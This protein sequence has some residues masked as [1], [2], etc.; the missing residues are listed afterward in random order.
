MNNERISA[1][2]YE[3][4]SA[5]L[6]NEL[7]QEE[8]RR[9]A[10]RL[11]NEP[12]LK[13]ALEAIRRTRHILRSQPLMRAP[14]NYTLSRQMVAEKKSLF[15]FKWG[16]KPAI[17][18]A[19]ALASVVFAILFLY[20]FV[21][22]Q[23]GLNR[24]PMA[25]A[26]APQQESVMQEAAPTQAV[27]DQQLRSAPSP[28]P[29]EQPMAK[30]APAGA[31]P[32]EG[33]PYPFAEEIGGMGGGEESGAPAIAEAPLMGVMTTTLMKPLTDTTPIPLAEIPAQTE[34]VPEGG[35]EAEALATS[36]AEINA[37][38]ESAPTPA[39]TAEPIGWDRRFWVQQIVLGV[40]VLGF[41]WMAYIVGR[42]R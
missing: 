13:E 41:A 24:V 5:Y 16:I 10:A 27:S 30:Q 6:D 9:F 18:T 37:M 2:D 21:M 29:P 7:A 33:Q 25:A 31:A 39:V 17:Q 11:Q 4:I 22:F 23:S 3:E 12:E 35:A 1:R 15:R 42:R 34:V 38:T 8:R 28:Y 36:E 32:A 26:P 20:N 19:S 40:A 14:R